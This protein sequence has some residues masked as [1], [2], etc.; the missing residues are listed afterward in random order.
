MLYV[1]MEDAAQEAGEQQ[2]R[3]AA[4]GVRVRRGRPARE[5]AGAARAASV[6]G[7]A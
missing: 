3:D 6:M 4:Y 1:R 2:H 7:M 5:R